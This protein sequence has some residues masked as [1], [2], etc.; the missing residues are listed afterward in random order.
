MQGGMQ[1]ISPTHVGD[2]LNGILSQLI[3]VVCINTA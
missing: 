3:L 1:V 2:R